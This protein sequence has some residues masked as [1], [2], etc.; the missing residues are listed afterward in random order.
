[1]AFKIV[2]E[3]FIKEGGVWVNQIILAEK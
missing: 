3:I 1:L 2:N